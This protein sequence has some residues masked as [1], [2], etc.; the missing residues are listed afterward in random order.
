MVNESE[1]SDKHRKVQQAKD[2]ERLE[3]KRLAVG[4]PLEFWG[5][6]DIST[7]GGIDRTLTRLFVTDVKHGKPV[8]LPFLEWV[9][10]P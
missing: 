2:V 1:L 8:F 7:A 10:K 6:T 9:S 4:C 5:Y 3:T